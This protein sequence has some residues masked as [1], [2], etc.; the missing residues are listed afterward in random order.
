MINLKNKVWAGPPQEESEWVNHLL[1]SIDEPDGCSERRESS[2]PVN[3]SSSSHLNNITVSSEIKPRWSSEN[4]RLVSSEASLPLSTE[5][6]SQI[7]SPHSLLFSLQYPAAEDLPSMQQPIPTPAVSTSSPPTT[8]EKIFFEKHNIMKWVID[9]QDDGDVLSLASLENIK[10]EDNNQVRPPP[11]AMY[12]VQTKILSYDQLKLNFDFRKNLSLP[13]TS[14]SEVKPRRTKR[15]SEADLSHLSEGEVSA[16]KYNRIRRLNN[17]SSRRC[18]LKKKMQQDL[19]LKELDDQTVHHAILKERCDAL[20][21]KVRNMKRFILKH[22]KNP[23]R[24]I[25]LARKRIIFGNDINDDILG[26]IVT[27]ND[28]PDISSIWSNL[29]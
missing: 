19:L 29:H 17:E 11:S 26:R 7:T 23:Q 10:L 4:F 20:E 12:V 27:T 16:R 22:F 21:S 9:D 5:T 25:A 6:Q 3:H 24:E 1:R 2:S 8:P 18:R 14:H 15:R 28:L 13:E